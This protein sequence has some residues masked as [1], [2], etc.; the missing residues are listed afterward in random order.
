MDIQWSQHHVLKG[1]SS[2][3]NRLGIS[4]DGL[5]EGLFLDSQLCSMTYMSVLTPA[6]QTV[7]VSG[8][9]VCF[10]IGKCKF[11][12]FVLLFQDGCGYSGF[13]E[14]LYEL[15]DELVN[16]YKEVRLDFLGSM[17]DLFIKVQAVAI[18]AT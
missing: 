12:N 5:C 15:W 14:F 6:H 16:F 9:L 1:L 4:F 7:F 10:I 3:P 11:S 17:L 8:A 18:F 13:L 2:P